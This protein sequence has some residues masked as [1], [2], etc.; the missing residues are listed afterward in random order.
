MDVM[1]EDFKTSFN[2]STFVIVTG[3]V[4][5]MKAFAEVSLISEEYTSVLMLPICCKKEEEK[6]FAISDE[7]LE[8]QHNN[9]W[10]LPSMHVDETLKSITKTTDF[11]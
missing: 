2:V 7:H 8:W 4:D 11:F 3:N 6:Y 10:E 5:S 9:K 1:L